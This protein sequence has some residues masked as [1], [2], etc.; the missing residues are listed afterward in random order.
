MTFPRTALVLPVIALLLGACTTPATDPAPAK[1][2]APM[3]A[4]TRPEMPAGKNLRKGMTEAEIRAIWGEPQTVHE[5]KLPNETILVYQFDVLSTQKMVAATV[6]ERA[7]IDP[8]TGEARTVMEP[9]LTPQKVTV[10][11]TIV[12]QLLDGQLASWARKLG[13]ERSFN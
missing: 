1:P 7:A 10:T 8:I 3:G 11:Q 13:E 9:V 4:T 2:T 6:V 12:L 5:G